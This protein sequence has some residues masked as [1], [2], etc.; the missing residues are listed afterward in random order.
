VLT[1]NR[2]LIPPGCLQA[3]PAPLVEEASQLSQT[4]GEW[5]SYLMAFGRKEVLLRGTGAR[6]L[7]AEPKDVSNRD[8]GLV[9]R[10]PERGCPVV[11]HLTNPKFKRKTRSFPRTSPKRRVGAKAIA[12]VLD[13]VD[14][15]DTFMGSKV[16]EEPLKILSGCLGDHQ[17]VGHSGL[18][19]EA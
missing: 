9:L 8:L 12:G 10:Q 18:Q 14:R 6:S 19:S 16:R 15:L 4:W 11:P 7:Q 3:A 13:S 17:L 2:Y 1:E 5:K